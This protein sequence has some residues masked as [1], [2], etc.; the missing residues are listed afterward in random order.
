MFNSVPSACFPCGTALGATWDKNLLRDAGRLMGKEGKAKG[1]H[2]LLGPCINMQRSPLGGRGFESIGED[3][4]LAGLGAAALTAGIQ[5]TGVGAC[6]KHFVCND[7]E[8]ERSL[9]NAIVTERALREIYLKPFQI[10]VRDARPATFMTS[11]NKLNG[12]HVSE[13]EK[14]LQKTLREEWGWEGLVMSDW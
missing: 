13:N 7:Q 4:V 2:V 3:P 1:A 10:A 8:H 5:D 14:I 12:V 11:Y 6:I 9:V